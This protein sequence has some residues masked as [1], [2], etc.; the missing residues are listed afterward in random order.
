MSWVAERGG[1]RGVNGIVKSRR[2]LSARQEAVLVHV[3]G[4]QKVTADGRILRVIMFSIQP[5]T[6][7]RNEQ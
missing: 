5:N 3:Q 6:T 2:K 1:T 7:G 4:V